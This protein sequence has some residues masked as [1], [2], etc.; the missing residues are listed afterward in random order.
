MAAGFS[1]AGVS[2]PHGENGPFQTR[3]FVLKDASLRQSRVC[4][5]ATRRGNELL[6]LLLRMWRH[7]MAVCVLAPEP[8]AA[9]IFGG[10]RT[11]TDS[12]KRR[13]LSGAAAVRSGSYGGINGANMGQK[14]D[15]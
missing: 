10:A 6:L 4:G 3:S 7:K 1:E 14:D 11:M 15:V 5:E 8:R 13:R 12:S 2:R 9:S